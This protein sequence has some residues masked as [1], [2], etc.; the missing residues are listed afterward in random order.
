M[1]DCSTL[2]SWGG[3][4]NHFTDAPFGALL[5]FLGPL[6]L[7]GPLSLVFGL[8]EALAAVAKQGTNSIHNQLVSIKQAEVVLD[9]SIQ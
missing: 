9:A 1:R 6:Q 3:G 8:A 4:Y 2:I 7:L 5:Q